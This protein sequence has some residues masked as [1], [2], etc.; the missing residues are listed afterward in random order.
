MR[1]RPCTRTRTRQTVGPRV[2]GHGGWRRAVRRARGGVVYMLMP[3]NDVRPATASA[4]AVV[5]VV[6]TAARAYSKKPPPGR[7]TAHTPCRLPV[8]IHTHYYARRTHTRRARTRNGLG[9]SGAP[10][11]LGGRSAPVQSRGGRGTFF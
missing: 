10:E 4:A 6:V 8:H 11:L 5:A 1:R 9:K 2:R 3:E 7:F